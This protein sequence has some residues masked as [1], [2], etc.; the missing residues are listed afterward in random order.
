MNRT[1]YFMKKILL[2]FAVLSL[3]TTPAMAQEGLGPLQITEKP[4]Y[5]KP[6]YIAMLWHRLNNFTP[7]FEKMAQKSPSYIGANE[8]E[9]PAIMTA[10]AA[11]LR[12][13]HSL[14]TPNEPI[15]I[16]YKTKAAPYDMRKKQIR[17]PDLSPSTFFDYTYLG[18]RYA[19]I[20]HKIMAFAALKMEQEMATPIMKERNPDKTITILFTLTPKA[21]DKN[22]LVLNNKNY[23][24][25]LADIAKAE[26]WS[27]DGSMVLWEAKVAEEVKEENQAGELLQL[28][29]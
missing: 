6:V 28:Y 25:I 24:L 9:R 15:Y 7:D 26:I 8:L 5:T 20:P 2:T 18:Q 13:I 29:Q 3:L 4:G 11:N 14:I 27:A 10:K 12:D 19:V 23:N 21:A 1:T 17:L 16:E 22:P